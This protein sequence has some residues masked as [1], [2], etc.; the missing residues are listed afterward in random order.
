LALQGLRKLDEAAEVFSEV[1][2]KA[3]QAGDVYAQAQAH[4]G[5]GY[6][7]KEKAIYP[8][9]LR[10]SQQALSLLESIQDLNDEPAVL[11][12]LGAIYYGMGDPP[13][14]RAHYRRS[15]EVFDR[16]GLRREKAIT[17]V[18][19]AMLDD[20]NSEGL[21][22]DS[23]EIG[24]QI[25]DKNLQ[26]RAL[27]FQ[28]GGLE[29][30][31]EFGSA[32]QKFEQ[33]A[34]LYQETGNQSDLAGVLT[35]EGV[36][37][38]Q[39]GHP[40]KSLGLYQKALEIQQRIGDQRGAIQ[41]I[42]AMAVAYEHLKEYSRSV[43]L[44]QRALTM[45]RE[46]GS[47]LLVNFELGNL[48]ACYTNLGRDEEAA[49]ILEEALAQEKKL[50]PWLVPYRYSSLSTARFHLGQF[51]ES[52]DAASHAVEGA[53]AWNNMDV[54]PLSLYWK[55]RAAAKL[56]DQKAALAAADECVQIIEDLRK[57]LVPND[58]MKRGFAGI[59]QDLFGLSIQLLIEAHQ[60]GRALQIAEQAR[61]RA[62][63]DLLATRDIRSSPER[64]E[65]LASLRKV[66]DQ[67]EAQGIDPAS[68]QANPSLN[69][70]TRGE[71]PSGSELLKQWVSGDAEL[72]SLV[73]A[74]PF[75]FAELQAT[76]H[77]LDSTVLSYWVW[78]DATY[79][80]VIAPGGSIHS[81]RVDVTSKRLKDLIGALW[82]GGPHARRGGE[83]LTEGADADT[84]AAK[85][86]TSQAWDTAPAVPT[87]SG[88][89]IA[90]GRDGRR[91]WRELY[92]LLIQPV[93][94]WLP[95]APGSL[96]TIE[97]HG[98]L[99]M[100]PFA[101]LRDT[102]GR[103]L[104]ERY[105]LHYVPAV[106]LL[107][108]TE[109]KKGNGHSAPNFLVVADPSGTPRGHGGEPLPPLAGARREAATVA[110]MLPRS[111]LTMLE[112]SRAT[113]RQVEALAG[114]STVLHFAT[115][116]I[117]RDDQP[118]ESYL[119]LGGNGWDLQHDGRL[120][121]Q[122][123][124]GLDLHAD[125]VFL[126]ACRSGLGQV[127]GDGIAG[128]TR[129]FLYAGTPSVIATLWDVADEPTYRL[130]GAF[131]RSWLTGSDKARALRSAQLKLL[132]E[133]RT[134]KVKVQTGA[135][136]FLLPEDP[137]FWASFALQGEP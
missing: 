42:N 52:L 125:L 81:S 47:P 83:P 20:P 6:V 7:L 96:L 65:Q 92:R 121:A 137:V 10:E 55:A 32:Q 40:D 91:N 44:Y 53:R 116:G 95:R 14:A 108:F 86:E 82:P 94:W 132:G 119:A 128:L 109:A 59:H 105:T 61:S 133:L 78:T 72:R 104:I 4:R 60:E 115:H 51:S 111:G 88:G 35:S 136:E 135:G 106:S 43:E 120:T 16:L 15:I 126:S 69:I 18:N 62:F 76:A 130:V 93:E 110:R 46:T 2:R 67:L 103:Y 87:R 38:R 22:E 79:I 36:L 49:R 73:S 9:A 48:A 45:A 85:G 33:A 113:Q 129:A 70:V 28:G 8:A 30:R 102:R 114:R 122:K 57:H 39:H 98:P 13:A 5:L 19:L 131:Y 66:R 50:N 74:E 1:L 29:L 26:A 24:R 63:L 80:W 107:R 12:Q 71:N 97:P 23:L 41:S 68:A 99:V 58:F 77:R 56:G 17:M 27:H 90:L 100:L 84:G 34:Q 124:Y 37:Q 64:Q 89:T 25:G 101:A 21:L 3:T 127:S 54:L 118:F 11:N 31:G 134:G 117:I 75:S 112:G 123:I